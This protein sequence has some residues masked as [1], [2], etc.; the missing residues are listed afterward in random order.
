M[1]DKKIKLIIAILFLSICFT[2]FIVRISKIESK[3]DNIHS[4][5]LPI[6]RVDCL[7]NS[8]LK[9][10]T[11][12]GFKY[13]PTVA[14]ITLDNNKDCML[15]SQLNSNYSNK[16]INDIIEEGDKLRKDIGNDT[17]YIIKKDSSKME[18]YYFLLNPHAG[19]SPMPFWEEAWRSFTT[20]DKKR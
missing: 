14:L 5:F 7:N 3:L 9:K 16:G 17:I 12:K 13:T 11:F 18:I 10:H 6:I 20:S 4:R 19:D 8:V 2:I 1:S 15:F